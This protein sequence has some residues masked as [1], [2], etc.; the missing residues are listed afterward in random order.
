MFNEKYDE[1]RK[2]ISNSQS[3]VL[4][5][6]P[7]INAVSPSAGGSGFSPE[8]LHYMVGTLA[9]E[10]HN[11]AFAMGNLVDLLEHDGVGADSAEE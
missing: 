1:I 9:G 8:Q 11:I 4:E 10:V 3:Q 6:M 7:L 5:V 2:I